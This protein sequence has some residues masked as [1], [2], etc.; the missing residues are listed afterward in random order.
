[1]DGRTDTKGDEKGEWNKE[2]FRILGDLKESIPSN[3]TVFVM[4]DSGLYSPK[5]YRL[6]AKLKW[7]PLMR[8]NGAGYFK[9]GEAW[10][11]LTDLPPEAS[12]ACGHG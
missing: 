4:T 5:I 10:L 3:Y 8:T 12:N 1:M 6:I 7:H 11:I 2:W 9:E